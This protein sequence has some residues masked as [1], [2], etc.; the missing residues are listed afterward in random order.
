MLR[1]HIHPSC[2]DGERSE[3]LSTQGIF[4]AHQMRGKHRMQWQE[5]LGDLGEFQVHT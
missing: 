4:Q 2:L 1:V 5:G 3:V